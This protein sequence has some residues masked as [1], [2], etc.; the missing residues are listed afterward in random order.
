MTD[1]PP[2]TAPQ[3]ITPRSPQAARERRLRVSVWVL[4]A[5]VAVLALALVGTLFVNRLFSDGLAEAYKNPLHVVED[6]LQLDGVGQAVVER[7]F[8]NSGL[9]PLGLGGTVMEAQIAIAGDDAGDRLAAR[10]RALGYEFEGTQPAND[11]AGIRETSSWRLGH[12]RVI[13]NPGAHGVHVDLIVS[14]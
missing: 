6:Q 1:T 12:C 4:S 13:V 5:C 7:E 2:P 8:D 3:P 10:L 9:R 14:S 11:A